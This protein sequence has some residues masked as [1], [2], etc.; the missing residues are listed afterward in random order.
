MAEIFRSDFSSGYCPSDDEANGRQNALLRMENLW[1]DDKGSIELVR[2][3]TKINSS[4]FTSGSP[5][6]IY[7][8]IINGVKQRYA[9]DNGTVKRSSTNF[10]GATTV[11]SGGNSQHTAFGNGFGQVFVAS[12]T[13]HAKKD[14]GTTIRNWGIAAPAGAPST[15]II[16]PSQLNV[17]GVYNDYILQEG[18]LLSTD[19]SSWVQGTSDATTFRTVFLDD[20]N[21][22]GSTFPSGGT[23]QPYD[24]F[25]GLVFV[26]D[27]SQVYSVRV[28]YLLQ[29]PNVSTSAPDVTDYFYFEFPARDTTYFRPGA[30]QWSNITCFRKDFVRIGSDPTLDWSTIKAVRVIFQC[31][32]SPIICRIGNLI[33]NGGLGGNLLAGTADIPN[34]YRWIQINVYNSGVYEGKS[35]MSPSTPYISV[36]NYNVTLT[37]YIAGIDSQVNECWFFRAGGTLDDF[38]FVGK[39]APGGSFT[40]NI[41]DIEALE[42]DIV[43]NQFLA[44]YFAMPDEILQISDQY[45]G[46]VIVM[47]F[48]GLYISDY[49]NPDAYDT[50][51][52]ILTSSNVG[53][54][55][56]FLT[57]V[58]NSS[59]VLG[60]TSDIYEISGTLANLPDGTM[61]IVIRSLGV[62]QPPLCEANTVY[63]NNLIYIAND[64]IRTM[65]GST[66]NVLDDN[67]LWL[68]KGQAR[69]G[70]LGFLIA[71]QDTVRYGLAARMNKLWFL[72][73]TTNSE[74]TVFVY[75]FLQKYW[76]VTPLAAACLFTEEDGELIAGF[77]DG[78]IR[79]LDVTNQLDGAVFQS[80]NLRTTL[81]NDL[82]LQRK[83]T[84]ALK[85]MIDTGGSSVD[86]ALG[87]ENS[88]PVTIKSIT[89]NGLKEVVVPLSAAYV[90]LSKRFSL[91]ITDTN[92]GGV[93]FF[94]LTNWSIDYEARPVPLPYLRIAP[95]QY[96]TAGRKRITEIPLVIDTLG[97]P[98][99]A[100]PILDGIVTGV[101]QNL[102]TNE[103]QRACY[104]FTQEQYATD[105]GLIL[106]AANGRVFEFYNLITPRVIELLPDQV[107]F[108]RIPAD[109]LGTPSR[110]RIIHFAFVID[111]HGQNVTFTP[112]VDNAAFT[113]KVYNTSQKL[114]VIYAFATEVIGTDIWGTLSGTAPFEYYGVNLE[115]CVTEKMPAPADFY[116]IPYNNLGSA[117]MKRIR[118][119]PLV[120]NTRGL[121]VTFTPA[122]DGTTYP[123]TIFNTSTKRTVLHYFTTDVFGIDLG[124]TLDAKGLGVYEFYGMISPTNVEVL[125]VGKMFDQIGPV[126]FDRTG[127]LIGFKI[128]VMPEGSSLNYNIFL[129][130]SS[131]Y[132]G[133]IPVVPN[134]DTTYIVDRLPMG[135]IGRVCRIEF[136]SNDKPFH[137]WYV[138]LRC[139]LSGTQTMLKKYM[140]K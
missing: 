20:D 101:S 39:C 11:L 62:K 118:T 29:V 58:S 129:D 32:T 51:T 137:R 1:L 36:Y 75:D 76:Y 26:S 8:K 44:T 98:V 91:Q 42:I 132:T 111:T 115:E 12:G 88:T 46:R 120:I 52:V 100:Q 45:M 106:T 64:G 5:T 121:N 110:K 89:Q 80:I 19:G 27:I 69:Y 99:A 38:Y 113:G 114:T 96:G 47:S 61:D 71:G 13:G 73:F 85:L 56:L 31:Y 2:G 33:F 107:E 90:Y 116:V 41:S 117:E 119:V 109:N 103:K 108:F 15:S 23:A 127:K 24:G 4:P 10:G 84:Y 105:I 83:D 126:E 92:G 124:G 125:P 102:Q 25:S 122:V 139:N 55:N 78:Y 53:E 138:E 136:S 9:N 74:P 21:I 79:Q 30:N 72:T 123:P 59:F 77:G 86:I 93:S 6:G 22:D 82:P 67:L 133:A 87:T 134:V 97:T 60:T 128:R 68:W 7:S 35:P 57:K 50:R 14:D 112:F 131:A 16:A 17:T 40:D 94:R 48:K 66:S 81:T 34:P 63:S 95:D 43:L 18:S 130:D 65:L 140:V 104:Y 135:L 37:P 28:E 70:Q 3:T 49:L 54:K